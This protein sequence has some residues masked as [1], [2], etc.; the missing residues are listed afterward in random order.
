MAALLVQSA[1][2][3]QTEGL[4]LLANSLSV[5]GHFSQFDEGPVSRVVAHVAQRL[6]C[7]NEARASCLEFAQDFPA[8]FLVERLNSVSNDADTVAA[9]KQAIG[10]E[11]HAIF[12]DDAEH[13]KIGVGAPAGFLRGS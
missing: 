12:S 9:A 5:S 10:G 4:A 8:F 1:S 11:V 6:F 2:S 3:L 13:Q 7:D